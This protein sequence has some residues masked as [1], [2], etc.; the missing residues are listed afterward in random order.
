VSIQIHT[1]AN[2]SREKRVLALTKA[3]F[4]THHVLVVGLESA[5]D[6]TSRR[7]CVMA[8]LTPH[9]FVLKSYANSGLPWWKAIAELVDNS[10][11]ADCNRVVIS[12][13][14]RIQKLATSTN[15]KL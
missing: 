8:D 3:R 7:N 11:S 6:S 15:I 13:A 12:V 9:A 4:L 14:N 2:T 5:K 10:I 1:V